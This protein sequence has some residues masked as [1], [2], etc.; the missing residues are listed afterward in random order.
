MPTERQ[1]GQTVTE[2]ERAR[3]RESERERE[4]ARERETR[5]ELCWRAMDLRSRQSLGNPVDCRCGHCKKLAPRQRVSTWGSPLE[6]DVR[7]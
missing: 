1:T 3:E 2:R 4:R 7:V 6:G 5:E